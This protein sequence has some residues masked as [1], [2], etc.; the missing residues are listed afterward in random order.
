MV[1]LVDKAQMLIAK[2]ALFFGAERVHGLA[3]QMHTAF[4]GAVQATQQ[5]QQCTFARARGPHNGQRLPGVHL[6]TNP[7]QHLHIQV[8]IFKALGQLACI[9]N[10]L[11]THNA[12][13]PQGSRGWRAS[14]GKWW[15]QRPE[16]GK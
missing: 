3:H 15:P 12:A 10:N 6:Q 16:S 1:E 9:Q 13:P 8:P 7:L 2:F 5:V 4:A 11:I 14:W